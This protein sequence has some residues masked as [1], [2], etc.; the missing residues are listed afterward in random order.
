MDRTAGVVEERIWDILTGTGADIRWMG[1][2]W[3]GGPGWDYRSGT[4][5]ERERIMG[6]WGMGE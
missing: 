5:A 3:S 6:G 2:G 1:K 4:G